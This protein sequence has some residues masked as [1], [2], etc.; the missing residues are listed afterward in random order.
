MGLQPF[1]F[2]HTPKMFQPRIADLCVAE[3]QVPECDRPLEMFQSGVADLCVVEVQPSK[4]GHRLEV[5]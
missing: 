1:E 5:F 4:L 2:G 3:P